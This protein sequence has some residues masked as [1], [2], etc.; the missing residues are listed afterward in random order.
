M[1]AVAESAL[2]ADD[3]TRIELLRRATEHDQKARSGVWAACCTCLGATLSQ[4][5]EQIHFSSAVTKELKGVG[6]LFNRGSPPR[7]AHKRLVARPLG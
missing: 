3:P 7:A 5:V 1:R 4:L 2:A 6:A